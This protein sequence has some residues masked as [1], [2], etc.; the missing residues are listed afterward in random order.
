MLPA[1]VATLVAATLLC[2]PPAE[3][4]PPKPALPVQGLLRAPA[5]GPVADGAY[6]FTFRLYTDLQ[7]DKPTWKEILVA[8]PVQGGFFAATLGSDDTNALPAD[9]F[10]KNPGAALS[11]QVAADLELPRMPLLAV[12]YALHAATADTIAGGLTG[13]KLAAGSVAAAALG[14]PYAASDSKGGPA[15]AL[16]CTG[17]VALEHLAANVLDAKNVTLQVPAKKTNVADFLQGFST[18]LHPE[19]VRLGIGKP[20]QNNCALDVATDGGT[21]CIDGAPALWTRVAGSDA[22][23]GKFAQDGVFVYRKDQ[24]RTWL[25]VKGIWRRVALDSV[26]GDAQVE[27]P[28]ECDNGK[29]NAD[30]PNK[31][32]TTCKKPACGDKLVDASE[33]C[34]DGNAVPTDACIA[35]KAA[36]CGDGYLQVGVEECD[37]GT[38]NADAADKCR[39]T[40]KKPTCGDK[41]ADAGEA[42]DDG[43][44]NPGDGC[45][46]TCGLE[47]IKRCADV[48]GGKSGVYDVDPDGPGGTVPFAVWCDFDTD[49]GGWTLVMSVNTQDG[50][51]STLDTPLWTDA[52]GF[53]S[54]VNRWTK[55]FKSPAANLVSGPELLLVVRNA[56]AVEG[57]APIG[58]R[59]WNLNG[60]K[61][62]QSFFTVQMGSFSANSTGGCNGGHAGAGWKQTTGIRS[63][64]VAAPFDTFTG[65]AQDIYSNS[66]YGGCGGTADGFRLSSWY[67]WANN[68]NVGLGLQMDSDSK[69][70][71]SLE[72]GSHLKIDT[73]GDPQRYCTGG[74]AQCTAYPD[75]GNNYTKTKAAIGTDHYANHCS[76]GVAY[77]YEWYV[78]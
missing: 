50:T 66:Y 21:T 27:P 38:A 39:K 44:K 1:T 51:L 64:G 23:M 12:P 11:V 71:Y 5:G 40:C 6:P 65:F 46:A 3:A 9:F 47:S 78:K 63:S 37:D 72:A 34:D 49:G 4:A 25:Y 36:S 75:G 26:C 13:D 57:A 60:N 31:C 22:E 19:D 74:C 24:G 45:S 17:C 32:K 8:V 70:A 29:G 43:N 56:T 77:R 68:A 73:Y 33:A 2:A 10:A 62:F 76:V 52:T 14:F 61:T 59:S 69:G 15:T 54:F 42:C 7:T 67:R 20:P 58:W 28:E 30:A 16:K 41:I 55:D 48:N 53:G 35:C 18:A